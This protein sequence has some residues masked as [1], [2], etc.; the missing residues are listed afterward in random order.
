MSKCIDIT[1]GTGFDVLE[2]LRF[3]EAVATP[4]AGVHG[5]RIQLGMT[6]QTD[7]VFMMIVTSTSPFHKRADFGGSLGFEQKIIRATKR[8]KVKYECALS[9]ILSTFPSLPIANWGD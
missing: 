6:F 4:V 3:Q 2:R 7:V 8:T 1:T 9:Y 5:L